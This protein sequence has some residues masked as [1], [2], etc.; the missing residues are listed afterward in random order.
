MKW[1]RKP[2]EAAY[3]KETTRLILGGL[4]WKSHVSLEWRQ[5]VGRVLEEENA[6]ALREGYRRNHTESK[7]TRTAMVPRVVP[8]STLG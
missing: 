3:E 5:P 1:R 7:A 2:C 4:P 6:Q 8:L